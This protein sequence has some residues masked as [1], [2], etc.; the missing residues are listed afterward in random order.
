M[1][2][3]R[4]FNALSLARDFISGPAAA[5]SLL[6]EIE[7]FTAGVFSEAV[8]DGN[9]LMVL[10]RIFALASGLTWPTEIILHLRTAGPL[11]CEINDG[12]SLISRGKKR[13]LCVSSC[14]P[15]IHMYKCIYGSPLNT[16]SNKKMDVIFDV[17]YFSWPYL[18]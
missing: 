9:S 3:V 14:C 13:V 7:S 17:S 8:C 18:P 5:A 2:F 11:V 1:S 15:A 4:F 16:K 10:V 6:V 12:M